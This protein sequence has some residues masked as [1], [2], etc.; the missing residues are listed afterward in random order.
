MLQVTNEDSTHQ[1]IGVKWPYQVAAWSCGLLVCVS[2]MLGWIAEWDPGLATAQFL[3]LAMAPVALMLSRSRGS[4]RLDRPQRIEPVRRS[5]LVDWSLSLGCALLSACVSISIASHIGDLPP[6]YHDEYSYLFQAKTLLAGRFSFPSPPDHTELFNQMHVLNEGRM[7][8][9]HPYGGPHC[10]GA[11]ATL[12][13]FWVGHELGGRLVA[14]VTGLV[15]ALSPG[16]GLFGNML[17]AHHPT[18]VGLGLFLLG[19]VRLGRTRSG[20]DA[21]L[22]GCGLSYAMLCRPMTAAAVG[23]PFGVQVVWWLMRRE[24]PKVDGLRPNTNGPK[25]WA[26]WLGLGLPLIAG[27]TVM[28]AYNQA[29]TGSWLSSP[30][31][32]YTDI[33]TPRHVYGFDNVI[34]GERHLGPKVIEQYDRWAENLTPSLATSNFLIRLIASW[35]WT[36][37]VLPLLFAT[38]TVIAARKRLDW[39]GHL[40]A[41]SIFSLHASH[42]PY[43]YVGIMGWHYV[44]ESAALWSL[45]LAL[46]TQRL[47]LD[48]TLA[49][50]QGL[51]WWWL[52]LL[53]LSLMGSFVSPTGTWKPRLLRGISSLAHPRR[54]QADFRQWIERSIRDRPALI[55]VDQ[56]ETEASHLD[57]V[58]NEPGLASD[59]IFGHLPKRESDLSEIVRTFSDRSVYLAI[60]NRKSLRQLSQ[61]RRDE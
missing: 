41:A 30:Y 14:V 8:C 33:Y 13:L 15:M 29:V 46:A 2:A 40:V 1:G 27:W 37:D 32:L 5:I 21:A 52:G 25:K 47:F 59:L 10:A 43:W 23:L 4:L 54:Q 3:W 28:L 45:L 38:A 31:Q 35:L 53:A 42:V 34:R 39:R 51:K 16:V 22:A 19:I 58:M 48:W 20:W 50:H 18:L 49:R 26:V 17:L 11:I 9:R 61:P 7:G 55:L 36:L 60:P 57:F 56:R 24:S 12:L 6:A 44:F